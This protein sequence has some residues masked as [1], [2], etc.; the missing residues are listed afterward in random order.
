MKTV[1]VM[2]VTGVGKSTIGSGLAKHLHCAF[3]DAD[4]YHPPAN[5]SKMSE[6]IPLTDADRLPWLEALHRMLSD[7]AK[8]EMSVVLACSA[9][10]DDYR[11]ILGKDLTITWIYLKGSAAAIRERIQHRA[12][13]FAHEDLLASQFSTLEEPADAIVIDADQPA[14]N[15][16][17]DVIA[18][19]TGDP[20]SNCAAP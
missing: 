19:V 15:V 7:Y 11:Q 18:H 5:I 12:G 8:R 20:M 9:L 16:L 6:G 10:R 13:H 2:G 4:Q 17:Q 1:V 3:E 14:E